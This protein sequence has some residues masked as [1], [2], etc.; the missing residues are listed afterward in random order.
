MMQHKF[1]KRF[2]AFAFTVCALAAALAVGVFAETAADITDSV[3][4]KATGLDKV[5][6]LTDGSLSTTA[7]GENISISIESEQPMRR[8]FSYLCKE[9]ISE[10]DAFVSVMTFSA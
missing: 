8:W 3:T 10:S 5:S 9:L 1:S 6:V 7:S 4:I 2:L